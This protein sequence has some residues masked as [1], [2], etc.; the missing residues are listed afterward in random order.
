MKYLDLLDSAS[1]ATRSSTEG[2]STAD[3]DEITPRRT[4][5]A[6]RN[7][8][9]GLP[10]PSSIVPLSSLLDFGAVDLAVPPR[11]V[12]AAEWVSGKP[13]Y[14]MVTAWGLPLNEAQA[15]RFVRAK[16][17]AWF[18]ALVYVV[19]ISYLVLDA[20]IEY[21][22]DATR[23]IRRGADFPASRDARFVKDAA[24]LGTPLRER[25]TY[26]QYACRL[27]GVSMRH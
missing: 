1:V 19:G 18:D 26:G 8:G 10:A 13:C 9:E 7:G 15:A 4:G 17:D 20:R 21:M 12:D 24:T 11:L 16:D 6:S 14:T 22:N 5:R 25:E 3:R 2:K 27:F 23:E